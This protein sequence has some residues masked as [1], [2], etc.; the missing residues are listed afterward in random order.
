MY[1]IFLSHSVLIWKGGFQ[2]RVVLERLQSK[3]NVH[4]HYKKLWGKK[5]GEQCFGETRYSSLNLLCYGQMRKPLKSTYTS[6]EMVEF[7]HVKIL[8]YKWKWSYRTMLLPHQRILTS[9]TWE[10]SLPVKREEKTDGGEALLSSF[11]Q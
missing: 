4:F 5:P 2:T 10:D 9:P 1:A 8:P 6:V 3:V 7:M 11:R